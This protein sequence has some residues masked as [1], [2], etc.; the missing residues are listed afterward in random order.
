MNSQAHTWIGIDVL[1]NFY[2][3]MEFNLWMM[4]VTPLKVTLFFSILVYLN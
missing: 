2:Q 4:D 1:S 3:I